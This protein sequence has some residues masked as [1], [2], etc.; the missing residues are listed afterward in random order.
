MELEHRRDVVLL[1]RG[2]SQIL[3][4]RGTGETIWLDA[5]PDGGKFELDFTDDGVSFLKFAGDEVKDDLRWKFTL[6]AGRHPQLG[7]EESSTCAHT[8]CI[9]LSQ[10]VH[11]AY[12]SSSNLSVVQSCHDLFACLGTPVFRA[13]MCLD[14]SC[15]LGM[16]FSCQFKAECRAEMSLGLCMVR[17]CFCRGHTQSS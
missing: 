12:H 17:S 2:E 11:V 4:H 3:H 13:G 5:A 15:L 6:C 7:R 1:S 16:A 8:L 9:G 10:H 14:C